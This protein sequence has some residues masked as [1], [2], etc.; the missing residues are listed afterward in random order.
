METSSAFVA[1]NNAIDAKSDTDASGRALSPAVPMRANNAEATDSPLAVEVRTVSKTFGKTEALKSVSLSVKPGEMVA[2]IGA[3]G[4]GKSTLLK[5]L[6]GLV[7]A[8]QTESCIKVNGSTIQKNGDLNTNIRQLRA[9]IGFIF[10]QFNLVGRM[11]LLKNVMTGMLAEIP[12]WRSLIQYFTHR[13]KV[14][15][16]EAL[17]RVGMAQY[18]GQ[19]ASTLS[20]GQ[21]QRAAIARA[22]IQQAKVILADEPI[23]SLDP[24]S[25]RKV[26]RSLQKINQDD[27]VT[28]LVSLHQVDFAMQYCE[29]IVG[30]RDGEILYDG[31]SE[32][33]TTEILRDLYGSEF[34]DVEE[35]IDI[36]AHLTD[37]KHRATE[38]K[39]QAMKRH[40]LEHV[41][42]AEL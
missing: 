40:V 33:L 41:A 21:Q 32:G 12:S 18:A 14:I 7:V 30:L 28:V 42:A 22:L 39:K 16:M 31:S 1:T 23:A 17:A 38:Q 25:S 24:E 4:S 9:H 11:P 15:A 6:S 27:N 36:L 2:L 19:R 34:S 29:R 20:G 8:N 26:M 13:E 37:K 5:H 10:Q 35:G 3:S